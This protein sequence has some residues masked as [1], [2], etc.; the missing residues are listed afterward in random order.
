MCHD[1]PVFSILPTYRLFVAFLLCV[2]GFA[3]LKPAQVSAANLESTVIRLQNISPNQ[4][5]TPIYVQTTIP[6]GTVAS[7]DQIQLVVPAQWQ[8][9]GSV[10]VSSSSLPAGV[11]AWPGLGTGSSSGQTVTFASSDLNSGTT[12]GF[13]ITS[14]IG[15][16]PSSVEESQ[17]QLSTRVAGSEV[18]TATVGISILP[19]TGSISVT[20]A[21]EAPA[22]AF[23]VSLERTAPVDTVITAGDTVSYQL[24]YNHSLQYSSSMTIV[25]SWSSS[26]PVLEYVMGSATTAYGGTAPVI[27]TVNNTI[28]WTTAS[29]PVGLPDQVVSFS[30]QAGTVVSESALPVTI[31]AQV[32]APTA[33]TAVSEQLSYQYQPPATPTPSPTPTPTTVSAAT[34]SPAPTPTPTP[35]ATPETSPSATP[36]VSSIR[37]ISVSDST[38]RVHVFLN[39]ARDIT[40]YYQS[41]SGQ[42]SSILG[43]DKQ[44]YFFD[45]TNLLSA[46]TYT[47]WV[48]D[49]HSGARLHTEQFAF[50]TTSTASRSV[51]LIESGIISYQGIWVKNWQ[52]TEDQ[53]L[54]SQVPFDVEF[55]LAVASAPVLKSAWLEFTTTTGEMLRFPLQQTSVSGLR[56][57]LF[58]QTI[59]NFEQVSLFARTVDGALI[60][61]QLGTVS[62]VPPIQIVN[63]VTGGPV[64][65]AEVVVAVLNPQ[66]ET[67]QV[68][69]LPEGIRT[70]SSQGIVPL[71]LA[72][73]D[74]QLTISVPGYLT[75]E[76]T[77]SWP[78]PESHR[79][80]LEPLHGGLFGW[81]YQ[82]PIVFK[83]AAATISN[84]L[85]PLL[86]T[87][88][89]VQTAEFVASLL[90]AFVALLLVAVFGGIP[91]HLLPSFVVA[92][93]RSGALFGKLPVDSRDIIFRD[94]RTGQ[95]LAGVSVSVLDSEEHTQRQQESSRYG[96]IKIIGSGVQELFVQKEGY[97]NATTVVVAAGA[98]T[99][100]LLTPQDDK[101]SHGLH[102]LKRLA[103]VTVG[104]S[105]ELLLGAVVLFELGMVVALGWKAVPLLVI[106]LSASAVWFYYHLVIHHHLELE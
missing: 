62:L 99:E 73:G 63:S 103:R 10:G 2:A 46:T 13:Y 20:G 78:T 84:Q 80:S 21:V 65:L 48:T 82:L 29:M 3:L 96:K 9:S 90:A 55:V 50:T 97:E 56:T 106:A 49:S 44:Q 104:Y 77:L 37:V 100:V 36:V 14:G 92:A 95:L 31:Q 25:A 91:L 30:L 85:V 67:Y 68:L 26:T 71:L 86:H 12:Y 51:D 60:G 32:T 16:N 98:Q 69:S 19:N 83:K 61:Q 105:I 93:A 39:S 81:I 59:Q 35:L 11:T 4:T 72:Q 1:I 38:A 40:L 43:S 17:W 18:D 54:V 7:E 5:S 15:A 88:S 47:F 53:I 58:F 94:A 102:V 74:Y 76:V 64:P 52:P 89:V 101:W 8:V 24:T 66:S 33:G 22:S 28:T 34:G 87:E 23:S 42:L 75:Q 45:I 27:D 79:I 70:S 6:A 57:R 41:E